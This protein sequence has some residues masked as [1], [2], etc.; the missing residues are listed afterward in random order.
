MFVITD[1]REYGAVITPNIIRTKSRRN[2]STGQ[3]SKC[4][5]TQTKQH[6]DCESLNE[7]D[8]FSYSFIRS[9]FCLK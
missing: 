4:V 2:L 9:V 6:G 8:S 7:S 3:K 1:F 5:D